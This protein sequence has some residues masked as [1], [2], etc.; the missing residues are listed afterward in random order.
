MGL[1]TNLFKE[2]MNLRD[3]GLPKISS[4]NH[5]YYVTIVNMKVQQCPHHCNPFFEPGFCKC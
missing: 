4:E 2:S 5:T 3:V 1:S